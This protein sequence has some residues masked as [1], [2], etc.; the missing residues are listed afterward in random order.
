MSIHSPFRLSLD[1]FHIR[2]MGCATNSLSLFL[3]AGLGIM[4]SIFLTI[5]NTPIMSE[6]RIFLQWDNFILLLRIVLLFLTTLKIQTT[7]GFIIFLQLNRSVQRNVYKW[8]LWKS[9]S[10]HEKYREGELEHVE[11]CR[12][13]NKDLPRRC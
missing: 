11:I 9:S 13:E 8:S 2:S 4:G 5:F 7:S 6:F 10:E 3:Y 1:S 12:G